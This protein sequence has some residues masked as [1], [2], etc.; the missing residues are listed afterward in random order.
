MSYVGDNEKGKLVRV[1]YRGVL[2]PGISR[3]VENL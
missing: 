2:V 1:K 3:V